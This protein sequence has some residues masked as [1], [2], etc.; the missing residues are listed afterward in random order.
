MEAAGSSKMLI[1]IYNN[2]LNYIPEDCDINVNHQGNLVSWL[3]SSHSSFLVLHKNA[4]RNEEIY[5][6][7]SLRISLTHFIKIKILWLQCTNQ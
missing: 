4:G 7:L 5:L 1:S 2:P 6:T 3:G